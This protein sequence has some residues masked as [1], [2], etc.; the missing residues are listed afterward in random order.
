[1][2]TTA[3]IEVRLLCICSRGLPVCSS[4]VDK[5]DLQ[6]QLLEVREFDRGIA[7]GASRILSNCCC[8]PGPFH[9]E[10]STHPRLQTPCIRFFLFRE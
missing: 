4:L 6:L 3:K 5:V 1:M 9:I 7:V 10:R 2:R 8:L